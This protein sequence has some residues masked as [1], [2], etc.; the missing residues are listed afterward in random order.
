MPP[1]KPEFEKLIQALADTNVRFVL[2]GGLAMV[3]HGSAHVT[4]DVDLGYSREAHNLAAVVNALSR[5]RP[6]LRVGEDDELPF[7]WEERTLHSGLNFTLR[8]DSGDID[9]LGDIPGVASFEELWERSLVMS[10]AD[11]E[12][13]VASLND[14]ISMKSAAGRPRDLLHL[15][16]LLALS[17]L[18]ESETDSS[19][20]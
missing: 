5:M 8:T 19:D 2:I 15:N 7:L 20:H 17:K 6:R 13:H 1:R 18:G 9:L 4:S 14:L 3:A 10:L 12:I 16:E 11:R